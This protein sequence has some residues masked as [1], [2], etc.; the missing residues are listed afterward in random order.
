MLADTRNPWLF[1]VLLLILSYYIACFSIVGDTLSTAESLS[2]SVSLVSQGSIFK[3]GFFKPGTSSNIY[4]GIWYKM[5][6]VK[7]KD[8]NIV[9]VANRENPLTD[10]SSSRL[11]LSEDGNL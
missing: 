8:I 9:W 6:G 10:P 7:V 5:F 4:L 1:S 3:L 2:V 11:E